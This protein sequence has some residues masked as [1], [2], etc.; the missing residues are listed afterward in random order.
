MERVIKIFIKPNSCSKILM[1]HSVESD[2][3]RQMAFQDLQ[4]KAK[5]R[6]LRQ[7]QFTQINIWINQPLLGRIKLPNLNMGQK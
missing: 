6:H 5:N 3:P 4:T 1:C 2:C 7:S